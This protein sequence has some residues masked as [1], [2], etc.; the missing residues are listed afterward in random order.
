VNPGFCILHANRLED[1][2]ALLVDWTRRYPLAP[3]EP[4]I[5]LVQNRGIAQWLKLALAEPEGH[6]IAAS[7]SPELPAR[8]LW[9]AYRA[10]LGDDQVPESS[11]FDKDAL[12]WK[13]M[14]HLPGPLSETLDDEPLSRYRMATRIADLFDQYQ[15]YRA[16]WMN[17]WKHGGHAGADRFRWQPDLWRALLADI[18]EGRSRAELHQAF[19]DAL[20]TSKE[21]PPRLPRRITVFGISSLPQQFIEALAA[22]G[23]HCQVLLLVN[24]PCRH[25]WADIV[26]DRRL[27]GDIAQTRH[28][29]IER[30]NPLLASWGKQGR[31][32]IG[33]LYGFD[34]PERYR[35]DFQQID[36]FRDPLDDGPPTLL[37]HLQQAIHDLAPALPD[38]APVDDSIRFQT[39]HS[40]Q[41][42]V[43]ILLD[44]LKARV[45][46]DPALEYRDIVVMTPEIEHYAPHIE[47]VFGADIPYSIADTRRRTDDAVLRTLDWL[48]TLPHGRIGLS[49]VLNL[50]DVPAVRRRFGIHEHH[51]PQLHEWATQAGVRWGLHAEQRRVFD[52]P[53]GYA[54][55]SWRAGIDRMLLGYANGARGPWCDIEPL[56]EVGGLSAGIVGPLVDLVDALDALWHEL[57][58]AATPDDWFARLSAALERFF[59]PTDDDESLTLIRI[60]EALEAWQTA[61]ANAGLAEALPVEVVHEALIGAVDD[62][63]R[64]PRFLYG[65]VNFCTLMP[66][67]AVPFKV[68]CLL[69][70]ND[71]VF[72]RARVPQDYDLMADDYRPGDR[73]RREDDRYQFLEAVLAARDHL[74]ISWIG[75]DIRSNEI[76]GPSVL[77]AQLQ[78]FL[79]RARCEALTT[80]HPL[81]PFSQ[82]YFD[83][84]SP[85]ETYAQEWQPRAVVAQPPPQPLPRRLPE[86]PL[87]LDALRAFLRQ[88]VDCFYRERLDI[89]LP[90]ELEVA[91]DHEP[92]KVG[93]LEGYGLTKRLLDAALGGGKA[94]AEAHRLVRE[95][96][97]PPGWVGARLVEH[98]LE[99]TA[100]VLARY[101][102][103]GLSPDDTPLALSLQTEVDGQSLEVSDLVRGLYRGAD[104]TLINLRCSP[105]KIGGKHHRLVEPWATHLCASAAGHALRTLFIGPDTIRSFRPLTTD[106]ARPLLDR[107]MSRWLQ[108]LQQPLPAAR[109]TSIAFLDGGNAAAAYEGGYNEAGERTESP[110]LARSW[111]DWET[112]A[113]HPEFEACARDMYGP[114]LEHVDDDA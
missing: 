82:R 90:R 100:A 61:C 64:S 48:L 96:A 85:L 24:N 34:D 109:R 107:L 84:S 99:A 35:H 102:E 77:V 47:A 97:I 67:R 18:G 60:A 63:H 54:Q 32:Y 57:R 65:Q 86:M 31:D 69:G 21:R 76:R 15:V 83:A 44:H 42:E 1:L 28:G 30:T 10:V 16:D 93:A 114:I 59:Q 103:L 70:M 41:R 108:G 112:L 29:G 105:N 88:P 8:F 27:L 62:T 14:R 113:A 39:A 38:D 6:G 87:S 3:L 92:F 73:S 37:R 95:G 12:T 89:V 7:I 74:Y 26:E 36:L 78:E 75:Q 55:N 104:G 13:L 49:E 43:E 40:R 4:E 98:G 5:V 52:L 20:A 56:D 11:P 25:Y 19:V 91:P 58:V 46:A 81:Q 66:M 23:R 53:E 80:A 51:V 9:S 68:V 110:W 22:L 45:E 50:L 79:G 106:E 2:R 33:M 71:R 111:P 94:E 17:D 101:A 72:P